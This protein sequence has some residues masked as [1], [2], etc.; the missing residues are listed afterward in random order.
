MQ[1]L[2]DG[3]KLLST[4]YKKLLR[5]HYS[6][7]R[8]NEYVRKRIDTLAGKQEPLLSVV[9]RRKL[10]WFGHVNRHDS[11]AQTILQGT[12]EGERRRRRQH[13]QQERFDAFESVFAP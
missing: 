12:V 7:H 13:V 9:K 11:L 6:E 8:T 2:R 10:T 1:R 5:I 4:C 3:C